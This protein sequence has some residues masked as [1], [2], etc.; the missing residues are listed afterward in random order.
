MLPFHYHSLPIIK[1]TKVSISFLKQ[2]IVINI[3]YITQKNM[4]TETG[5]TLLITLSAG[6]L[7]VSLIPYAKYACYKS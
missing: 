6:V 4:M 2:Y 1:L 5:E 7:R 3:D